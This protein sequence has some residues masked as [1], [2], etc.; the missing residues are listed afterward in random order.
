MTV[1]EQLL[2]ESRV[3]MRQ[4]VIAALAGILLV[5]AAAL[6]LSGPHT[7]VDELTLDLITAHKRFPIDVIGAAING[8]GLCALAATLAFLVDITRARNSEVR[9]FMR[10]LAIVGGVLAALSG[11][12]YAIV[13]AGKAD[14]FVSHGSQTYEQA[15]HL[16][17]SPGLLVLPFIGQAAALLLA[18]G[19][20]LIALQA[21][22]VG[23]LTRFMGYL[24]IFTGVLVLFPI[25][26]PVPVVQGFWLLALAYLFSGRWPNGVPPAWRSGQAEKWPSSA[27]LRQQRARA[28]GGGGRSKPSPKPAPEAVGAPAAGRTRAST[29]KRKRKRRR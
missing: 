28:A 12:V 2:Y 19:F 10:W 13:I 15:N 26:S 23:L 6:Q 14:T 18:V 21:M 4:A 22:R 11:I 16:T 5:G 29:G 25:G 7:K 1:D 17:R 24:G 9:G 8:V 27:D 20:V 3:R